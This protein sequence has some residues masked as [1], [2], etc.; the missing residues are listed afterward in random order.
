MKTC[1]SCLPCFIGQAYDAVCMATDKE[2]IRESV[3]REVLSEVSAIS[4]SETPP[5]MARTIHKIIREKTGNNDPYTRIK[6]HYNQKAMQ[7]YGDM[8]EMVR[9]SDSPLRTAIRLSIIGN[10]I[11]FGVRKE[12][13][14][15]DIEAEIKKNL[16]TGYAVN[17]LED[18]CGALE[19]SKEI[20]YIGDNSGEVVFD[21][22]LIEELLPRNVTYAVR[23]V[24]IIND[25]VRSDAEEAGI[26]RIAA[27]IESGSDAPGTIL[28]SCTPDFLR[29]F[30]TAD[31]VIS[32]GQGN[33]ETLSDAE[34][35]RLFFL[36]KAKCPVIADHAG[37]KVG[38]YIILRIRQVS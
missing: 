14:R 11:D 24:P 20:L 17:D 4:F 34:N 7:L 10:V 38:G 35:P 18:L 23:S 3:I 9:S 12:K 13:D 27:V 33:Y 5:H 2:S 25:A 8:K 36:L 15:I 19:E 28:D 37:C 16:K 22:V 1:L 30:N 31:I 6:K 21:R 29:Q 32:K 26:D